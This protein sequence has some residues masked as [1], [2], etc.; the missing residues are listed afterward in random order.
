LGIGERATCRGVAANESAFARVALDL[1]D[2]AIDVRAAPLH[3]GRRVRQ[4][5][6]RGAVEGSQ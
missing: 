1:L 2:L 3:S 4:A 6:I 5:T